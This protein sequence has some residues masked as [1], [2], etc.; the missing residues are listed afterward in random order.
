MLESSD[1]SSIQILGSRANSDSMG[2]DS[3]SH[4]GHE[5]VFI[6]SSD[7][8]SPNKSDTI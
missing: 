5:A 1:D 2:F 4:G 8:E 6:L 3:Y 7:D